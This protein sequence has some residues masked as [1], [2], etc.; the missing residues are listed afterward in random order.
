MATTIGTLVVEMSANVARLQRDMDAA[1]NTVQRTAADMGRAFE[2]VK[3]VLGGSAIILGI[4]SMIDH[5]LTL[6]DELN[7]LNQRT[8]ISVEALSGLRVAAKLADVDF[9]SVATSVGKFNQHLVEARDETSKMGQIMQAVGVDITQGPEVALEQFLQKAAGI[10][11]ASLKVAVFKEAFGKAGDQM[12]LVANQ[13]EEAK[14]AAQRMGLVM[15]G[16][17]AAQANQLKDNL[18]LLKMAGEQLGIS[19]MAQAVPALTETAAALARAEPGANRLK[20]LF[21]EL[22]K[23]FYAFMGATVGGDWDK[24][25][26]ALFEQTTPKAGAAAAAASGAPINEKALSGILSGGASGGGRG[27]AGLSLD[28]LLAMAAMKRQQMEDDANKTADDAIK[29]QQEQAKALRESLDPLEK[30]REQLLLINELE[31]AGLLSTLDAEALRQEAYDK[32]D[33]MLNGTYEAQ[34]KIKNQVDEMK[35]LYHDFAI[36]MQSAF[37]QA[38]VSGGK[39]SDVMRGLLKDIEQMLARK[40]FQAGADYLGDL[41]GFG[42]DK[43]G[44]VPSQAPGGGIGGWI[45]SAAS[46]VGSWISGFFADGGQMKPNTWNVVGERGPEVV[47]SGAGGGTVVPNGGGASLTQNFYITTDGGGDGND[48]QT[49]LMAL[50]P[51]MA[52]TAREVLVEQQKPGGLLGAR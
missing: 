3:S 24:R 10:Q 18:T 31:E 4:R 50:R 42:K 47:W 35:D 14:A 33:K 37:S 26:A 9:E 13:A 32:T 34:E 30:I 17:T 19:L 12:I 29:R 52:S 6:G 36:T 40:A 25:T 11:D 2:N 46:S 5:V 16:E 38:I 21:L 7:K 15:S 41:M 43:G 28:D 48:L 39:L 49:T 20:A 8:G 45:G 44:G 1:K 27:K 23:Y 22:N 51:Y